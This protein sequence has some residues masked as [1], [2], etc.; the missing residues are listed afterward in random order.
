V[1]VTAA[2]LTGGRARRLGGRD[3]SALILGTTTVLQ[4]QI[5]ALRAVTGSI[6]LVTGAGRGDA[7]SGLTVVR[8][9]VPAAGPL[10]GIYT[11]IRASGDDLTLVVA[12]D[13][14]FLDASFLARLVAEAAG[15]DVAVPRTADGIH[16]L[17]A[18]YAASAAEPIRRRLAR[19]DRAVIE[20]L[21]DLRVREMQ[22]DQIAPYDPDGRLLLNINTPDDY[23]RALSMCGR[24]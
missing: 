4:R 1:S 3:K 8:D 17:C 20:A 10:G 24:G 9:V 16:P 23:A 22:P 7:A 15:V 21:A 14:P 19:G 6:M 2:I 5:T 11:A 13:L 12:C 18:V